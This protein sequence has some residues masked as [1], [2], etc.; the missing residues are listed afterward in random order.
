MGGDRLIF[1]AACGRGAGSTCLASDDT[2]SRSSAGLLQCGRLCRVHRNAP[3]HV[4]ASVGLLAG[5]ASVF[6]AVNARKH[7]STNVFGAGASFPRGSH[8]FASGEGISG[9]RTARRRL[10]LACQCGFLRGRSGGEGFEPSVRFA[11]TTVFETACF[12]ALAPEC[13]Y[14]SRVRASASAVAPL[15]PAGG[16]QRKRRWRPLL[17]HETGSLRRAVRP[18]AHCSLGRI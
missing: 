8:S 12:W 3:P 15:T 9:S 7:Q 14:A 1:T 4:V 11:R 6:S 2:R 10:K 5:S 13:R 16:D 17:L 18:P